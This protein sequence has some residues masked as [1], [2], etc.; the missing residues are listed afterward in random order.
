MMHS[1]L[2]LTPERWPDL[3]AIFNARGC[4]VARGCWCMYYRRSGSRGPLPRGTTHAQAK[5]DE[6]KAPSSNDSMWFGAK[7]MYDSAGFKEVARQAVPS[8][9]PPQA[10]LKT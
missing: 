2:P 4:S 3:E 1:V 7:S 6:L 5:R 8:D 10:S 9:R